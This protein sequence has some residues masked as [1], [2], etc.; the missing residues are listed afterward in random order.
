VEK[1]STTAAGGV[2]I[3]LSLRNR[4]PLKGVCGPYEGRSLDRDLGKGKSAEKGRAIKALRPKGG[5]K[6][7]S[8][9]RRVE[10]EKCKGGF[11]EE[12]RGGKGLPG[13][14]K[15]ML[16]AGKREG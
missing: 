4:N 3:P 16:R 2:K 13:G 6:L 5:K 10:Q 9:K 8:I 1:N 11:G 14:K 12:V 7:I 15:L